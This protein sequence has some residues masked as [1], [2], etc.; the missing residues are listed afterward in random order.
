MSLSEYIH[1]NTHYTRSINMERDSD[2]ISV[3]EAYIPTTRALRTLETMIEA[4][5]AD[6]APRAWSLVGPYGSGKSSFAVFLTHLLGG[7]S[8][9][10]TQVALKKLRSADAPIAKRFS[11]LG[12]VSAGY[13]TVLLTGSPDSLAKRLVESLSHS[14]QEVWGAKPGRSP[15]I[16]GRLDALAKSRSI[17]TTTDVLECIE[18]LQD[19]LAKAG[20]NGL[21]IVID[22]LGKFLEYEAR[23]YGAND[24]YL[25]QAL[26]EHA[27]A[28]HAAKLSLVVML[29][30]AFEQYARGLGEALRN[31]W[32]KVQGRFENI[33]FLESVEQVLRVVAAAI[34]PSLSKA[35]SETIAQKA[36]KIAGVLARSK[37]LPG[38]MDEKTAIDLFTRC[39]PLH[40]ISAL[41]LP[42]LCQKVAQNERTLFSYLGSREAFGFADGIKR[43]SK[44]GDWIYPWEIYEYFILNQSAALSDH[45]THRRWAEVVIA[46]ERLGDAKDAESYVLKAIGLLNIIGAHGGFK[47]TKD[48]VSLC[49]PTKPA[50]DAAIKELTDKSII[51]YRK[52]SSEYRVWQGSDFDLDAAV[53]SEIEKLGRFDLT[54]SLNSRH[55]L[56]PIV[57]RKYTIQSGALR[58]FHPTFADGKILPD[59]GHDN[60][61]ARIVFYLAESK[62]D[63]LSFADDISASTSD[64]DIL[65]FCLSSDQLREA[66]AEVLALEA[67]QRTAQ[68]LNSDPVA[69]REFKDRYAA[70]VVREEELLERLTS[71]P[72]LNN[73]YWK[74]ELLDIDSKRS[75]QEELSRVLSITYKKSPTFKNELINRDKPSSQANAAKNKLAI[76]M[77]NNEEEANLGIEKFPPEKAIYLSCLRETKL[78]VL[79]D[80]GKWG[81]RGPVS[82]KKA[83]DPCNIYPVWQRIE[84]FL[85]STE[86]QA[87]SL[88]ELNLELIAPPYGVKVGMLPILYLAVLMANQQELAIYE[89]RIYCPYLSEEQIERFLKRPDEFTVQRFKIK[90]LNKSIHEVYSSTLYS[91]GEERSILALSKP[92]AKMIFKLPTYTKA[93]QVGLSARAKAVRNL[94]KL[95]ES[96]IKLM[97]EDLPRALDIDLEKCTHNSDELRL[98]SK[99]LMDTLRELQYCLPN[100]KD[101]FKGLLAQSVGQEKELE[102]A[103][104]REVVA[105]RCRG[106]EDYTIDRDGIRTFIQR[107]LSSSEDNEQW[108]DELLGFLG[109]KSP[110][111]WSDAERTSAEYRL[112]EL[113]RK[114]SELERLRLHYQES[115]KQF[116]GDFDVFLLRSVKKGAPDYDEVVAIDQHRHEA[117]RGIKQNMREAIQDIDSELKIAALAEL[118]DEILA[119]RRVVTKSKP[120]TKAKRLRRTT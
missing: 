19:A 58:Y 64:L 60:E 57:A 53:E 4:F 74:K 43:C 9:P 84:K 67:I 35:Q 48:I 106:L 120:V 66:T 116:D 5:E 114:L 18:S 86:Q 47:A 92:L 6:E 83:D 28:D 68:E 11:V 42:L 51:Q 73:W 23:H 90:G 94:F 96:P 30:Q 95:A 34:E 102:I 101:E 10:A 75:L 97:L 99:R 70:A 87:K 26:A 16:V 15:A 32:S 93:T 22:E 91:D 55:S 100:L 41:L 29:H 17:P 115:S 80:N 110:D 72:Q 52:F 54:E 77:F 36:S 104:L 8:A 65:V 82:A 31:E 24:I 118:V 112:V 113:S 103:K 63:E 61:Q 85:D 20:H 111:K 12:E 44:L 7:S 37:A 1:V 46:T 3:T 88:V 56:M 38:T 2:S 21:L 39:Y 50:I 45:F 71:E 98:L 59:L 62:S 78:H 49:L 117:I 109:Q 25:L 69:Q 105:G 108:F 14:A 76:A 40:P 79:G 119:E 33:P 81:F 89:S 13:C 27:L 107:A